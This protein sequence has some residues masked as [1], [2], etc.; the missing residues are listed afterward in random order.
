MITEAQKESIGLLAGDMEAAV[1]G[2]QLNNTE[3]PTITASQ[4]AVM[5]ASVLYAVQRHEARGGSFPDA[6]T[7]GNFT[8]FVNNAAEHYANSV[9]ASAIKFAEETIERM[10]GQISKLELDG[11]ES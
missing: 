1:I 6:D 3:V 10:S 8:D 5:L 7:V 4:Y 11:G 2:L 9:A